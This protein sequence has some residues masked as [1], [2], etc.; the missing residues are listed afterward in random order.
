MFRVSPDNEGKA[1]VEILRGARRGA[2][3]LH[4]EPT[5]RNGATGRRRL[6]RVLT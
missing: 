3:V 5:E 4:K 1:A 6:R 2:G